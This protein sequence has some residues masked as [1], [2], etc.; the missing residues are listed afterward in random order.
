M[1]H[2]CNTHVTHAVAAPPR[3]RRT[4]VT[5]AGRSAPSSLS[6]A[7]DKRRPRTRLLDPTRVRYTNVTRAG[8]RTA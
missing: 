3:A 5:H 1:L 2:T 6:K 8:R 4:N 7:A